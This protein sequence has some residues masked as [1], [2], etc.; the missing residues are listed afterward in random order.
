MAF[1]IIVIIHLWELAH[2]LWSW[3]MIVLCVW[4]Y[5][6]MAVLLAAYLRCGSLPEVWKPT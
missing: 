6:I 2:P 3:C 5:P 4:H 1:N